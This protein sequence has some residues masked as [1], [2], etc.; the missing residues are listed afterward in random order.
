MP[1]YDPNNAVSSDLN[2]NDTALSTVQCKH[3]PRLYTHDLKIFCM[4]NKFVPNVQDKHHRQS[5]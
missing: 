1:F 2:N 4:L 5:E 3:L